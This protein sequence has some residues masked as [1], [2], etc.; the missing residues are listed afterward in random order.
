MAKFNKIN[1]S[2]KHVAIDKA[3]KTIISVITIAAVVLVFSLIG[4][5]QLIIKLKHQNAVI[6]AKKEAKNRLQENIKSTKTLEAAYKT[7]EEKAPSV[8]G[9]P[10][11]NS[12]IILDALP[13]KYDFPALTSSLEKILSL[14]TYTE[15]S[16][17]GTDDE[18][19]QSSSAAATLVEMPFI[20]STKGT[21]DNILKLINDFDRSIRPLHILSLEFDGGEGSMTVTIKAKT[22][23]QTEERLEITTEEIK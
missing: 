10:D 2:I 17:E 8:L 13:S 6:S 3:A 4:G 1:F 14:N 23:Y 9:T 16:I 5:R 22:Y 21:Y 20:L 15:R 7:F 11:K 18:I 19:T 12:K